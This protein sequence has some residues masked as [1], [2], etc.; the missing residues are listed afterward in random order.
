MKKI[1]LLFVA[2]MCATMTWA[3]KL[4]AGP[5]ISVNNATKMFTV[6]PAAETDHYFLFVGFVRP[7][8]PDLANVEQ[9]RTT[10]M[11]AIESM[12]EYDVEDLNYDL[13]EGVWKGTGTMHMS[14]LGVYGDA[15][16]SSGEG[17]I[18]CQGFT[19]DGEGAVK[20]TAVSEQLFTLSENLP[21]GPAIEGNGAAK[22]FTVTPAAETDRYFMLV[23]PLD[24]DPYNTAEDARA[25]MEKGFQ[26]FYDL[27]L[28][29]LNYD[30]A[31]G[32]WKGTGTMTMQLVNIVGEE[33]LT[34]GNWYV[35]CQSYDI[36]DGYGSRYKG[37]AYPVS[38]FSE[39]VFSVTTTGV[40]ILSLEEYGQKMLRD[41]Q[42]L[43]LRDG[44][45]YNTVGAEL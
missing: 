26:D 40:S 13:A 9:L 2:A 39:C 22:L 16:L 34:P 30:V 1:T 25:E 37:K 32:V 41:G 38:E 14:I 11:E 35:I 31:E 27:D 23:A 43:I 33:K 18:L 45:M 12:Y 8:D 15:E 5:A 36:I 44:K 6:T 10:L 42:L 4:P 28:E 19:I 21:A 29:D 24:G 7:E 3:E 17:M 20:T